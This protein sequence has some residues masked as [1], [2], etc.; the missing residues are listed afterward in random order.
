MPPEAEQRSARETIRFGVCDQYA[1][2]ADQLARSILDNTPVPVPLTDAWDT[3]NAI[4]V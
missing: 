2:L 3:M 4:E 1:V